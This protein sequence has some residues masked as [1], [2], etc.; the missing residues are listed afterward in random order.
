MSASGLK[1]VCQEPYGS[2]TALSFYVAWAEQPRMAIQ[3]IQSGEP[4][5]NAYVK[6]YQQ[7]VPREFLSL[8]LFRNQE[9]REGT[10]CMEDRLQRA[11]S[12]DALGTLRR[13]NTFKKQR[14]KL[15]FKTVYL[16]GKLTPQGNKCRATCSGHYITSRAC[17]IPFLAAY[18][19]VYTSCHK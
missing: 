10:P 16:T 4:N 12:H 3:Y 18:T 13:K 5:Q 19:D 9:V 17:T 6:R 8:Y 2:T 14:R 7:D 11:P 15:Y 1:K